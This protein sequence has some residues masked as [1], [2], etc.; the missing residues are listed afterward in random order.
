MNVK[1]VQQLDE[2]DVYVIEKNDSATETL[3]DVN[4]SRKKEVGV[5]LYYDGSHFP[6]IQTKSSKYFKRT[7]KKTGKSYGLFCL[8]RD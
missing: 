7:N 1:F 3:L 6:Y 5:G 8:C 4:Y 2:N